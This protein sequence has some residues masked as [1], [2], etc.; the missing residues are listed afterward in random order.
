MLARLSSAVVV[1][2]LVACN[3]EPPPSN[4][5]K[6][7]VRGEL[8]LVGQPAPLRADTDQPAEFELSVRKKSGKAH[9]ATGRRVRA[10]ALGSGETVYA[11][12][13]QAELVRIDESGDTR[14]LDGVIGSPAPL[15]DGSVII[16]RDQGDTGETDL[17][18]VPENGAPR[19]IAP[20]PGPDDLPVELPDGR[21]AFVS[22]RSGIV[23]LFTV[24]LKNGAVVQLTN[25]GLQVG[26]PLTG[27]VPPPETVL[28]VSEHTIT[29]DAG[30]GAR[31]RVDTTS[32]AATQLSEAR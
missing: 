19:A 1:L 16:A 4:G 27:F 8:V 11:V 3:S 30:G 14:L 21:I 5:E 23:S 17:W 10:A 29:Y 6:L 24:D 15:R 7:D 18:L 20:A 12:T 32:G 9:R 31:W 26:K 25:R 13:P 22:G 2:S 28:E